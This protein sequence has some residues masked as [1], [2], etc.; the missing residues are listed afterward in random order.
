MGEIAQH[1]ERYRTLTQAVWTALSA[2]VD[3]LGFPPGTV[4]VGLPDAAEYRLE[5]DPATGL[6]SLVGIW[7]DARGNKCGTLLIH[8]DGSFF[9]EYD[10]IREHPQNDRWFVEAV[11]AWGRGDII[12]S[13]P[14]LLP[15][16]I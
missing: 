9:A 2:E 4:A 11:T 15:V 10:V 5:R 6:D 7:R 8:A 13:E 3:R 1:R 14:R 12:R 16:A